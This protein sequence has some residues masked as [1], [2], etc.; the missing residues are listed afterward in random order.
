MPSLLQQWVTIRKRLMGEIEK[1]VQAALYAGGLM[2]EGNAKQKIMAGGKSGRT[3][4]RRSV[5]HRA[6]APGEAPAN[7]TG[8]LVNSIKVE[9]QPSRKRVLV[10]AG[11]GAVEYAALL[12][13]GTSKMEERPFFRPALKEERGNIEKRLKQG[14]AKAQRKASKK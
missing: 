4:K 12:E 6:S 2:I 5:T 7:D 8:R 1:E 13:F 14:V 9:A 10:K 11:S 3:Y